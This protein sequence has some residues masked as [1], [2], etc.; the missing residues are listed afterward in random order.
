M[1]QDAKGIV[2]QTV[3]IGNVN[4]SMFEAMKYALSKDVPLVI[5]TRVHTGARIRCM[6]FRAVARRLLT[7]AR[8]WL[9]T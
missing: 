1:A 9:A 5:S 8:L 7:Q 2:L 4:V 3:G 6:G